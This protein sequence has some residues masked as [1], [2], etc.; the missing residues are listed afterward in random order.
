MAMAIL[1]NLDGVAD[2]LKAEYKQVTD[3]GPLK[4]KFVLTVEAVDGYAL[5]NIENLQKALNSERTQHK[6]SK[7][8]LEKFG[9]LT[10]DAA[11]EAITKAEEM[12]GRDH[13]KETEELRKTI[14]AEA[15]K[16]IDSTLA[17]LKT[18]ADEK[19]SL[20]GTLHETIVK[21]AAVDAILAMGGDER[22]KAWLLP[23]INPQL[24]LGRDESGKFRPEVVDQSG[25]ARMSSA[26][27]YSE[28]MSIKE[29]VESMKKDP[30][31]SPAFPAEKK[32]VTVHRSPGTPPA[33]TD[34]PM[35]TVEK[36]EEIRQAQ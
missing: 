30:L 22:T 2:A 17:N 24:R 29:L 10:P 8:K 28:P 3:E 33:V 4:G 14:E 35:S 7:A 21:N 16:K 6:E 15:Q 5:G 26:K 19:A 36:L 9:D 32:V 11:R 23:I 25:T 34:R 27:S 12:A 31:Y 18:L 1:E 13:G 20:E